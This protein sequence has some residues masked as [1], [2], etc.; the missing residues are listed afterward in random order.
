MYIQIQ[1]LT[2]G[3]TQTHTHINTHTHTLTHTHA[4]ARTHT[5]THTNVH[6]NKQSVIYFLTV[7]LF[8]IHVCNI[9]VHS[10]VFTVTNEHR[11]TIIW[12]E[13]ESKCLRQTMHQF[14]L[15]DI[16]MNIPI[17]IHPFIIFSEECIPSLISI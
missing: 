15:L 8:V 3:S 5:H 6:I 2:Q 12:I 4:Q 11:V 16:L 14:I 9:V 10:I 7:T 1:K 17:I 13:M